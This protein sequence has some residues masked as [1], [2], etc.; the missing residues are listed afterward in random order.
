M[1]NKKIALISITILVILLTTGYLYFFQ[2]INKNKTV[3]KNP[4]AQIISQNT[5]NGIVD[6]D[7]VIKQGITN[8][9]SDYINYILLSL[10]LG[11][12]HK[13]LL[14]YG[15]PKIE[16]IMDNDEWNSELINGGL[17]TQKGEITDPDIRISMSKEEAVK[18][19]LSDNMENFM[20]NSII[21]GNTKLGVVASKT[22]L[23]SKGYLS[24]YEKLT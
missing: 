21:N 19:L 18:A 24:V 8:F 7:A 10:G 11:K 20:K 16:L 3:L 2:P 13:S 4:I 23:A 5:K 1:M 6:N 9:N 14:G 17:K 15:N 22:E 12:L